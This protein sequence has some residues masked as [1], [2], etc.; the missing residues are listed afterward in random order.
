M[1]IICIKNS[2]LKLQLFTKDYLLHEIIIVKIISRPG[3]GA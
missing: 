2:Y 3:I 1:Q